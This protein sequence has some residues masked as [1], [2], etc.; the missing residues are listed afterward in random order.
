LI[1]WCGGESWTELI[2]I[3][4]NVAR[5]ILPTKGKWVC[6]FG[7][8]EGLAVAHTQILTGLHENRG[9]TTMP[10]AII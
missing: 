2:G 6:R 1:G 8:D 9:I 5:L 4:K 7:D 3:A 10:I